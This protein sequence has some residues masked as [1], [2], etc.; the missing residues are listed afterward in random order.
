MIS[1]LKRQDIYEVSIGIGK[2]TD[3]D[4]NDQL[5]EG[6]ISFRTI[7]LALSPS[8]HYLISPVEYP[9]DLWTKLDRTF[10]KHNED[11]YSDLERKPRTTR[12]IYQKL[13]S[14]ILYDE[15]VQDE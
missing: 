14:S 8:L 6:D 1:S 11:H 2:E 10:C 9:K 7:C 4:E 5:N 3:E 13:S 15:V 12:V